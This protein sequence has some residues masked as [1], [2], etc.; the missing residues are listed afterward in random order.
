M[1]VNRYTPRLVESYDPGRAAAQ[2]IEMLVDDAGFYVLASDYEALAAELAECKE[3]SN[4]E[5]I[6]AAEARVK[7]LEEALDGASGWCE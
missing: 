5:L 1:A 3:A 2:R 7:V 4:Y 6:L